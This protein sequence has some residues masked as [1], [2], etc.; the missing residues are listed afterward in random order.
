MIGLFTNLMGLDG[1]RPGFIP[2]CCT[3]AKALDFVPAVRL[4]APYHDYGTMLS[5]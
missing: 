1:G 4:V 3:A 5:A 2:S